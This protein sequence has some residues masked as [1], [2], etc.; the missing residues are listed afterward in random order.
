M[1]EDTRAIAC[2]EGQ[3]TAYK[4][5]FSSVMYA[6]G[7]QLRQQCIHPLSHLSGPLH[8]SFLMQGVSLNPKLTNF[9]ILAGPRVPGICPSPPLQ[10]RDT[11]PLSCAHLFIGLAGSNWGLYTLQGVRTHVCTGAQ[12]HKH[13]DTCSSHTTGE[14]S[15]GGRRFCYDTGSLTEPEAVLD[16]LT[17]GLLRSCL[18]PPML[19]LQVWVVFFF[20]YGW[21]GFEL[22]TSW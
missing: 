2:C 16:W 14:T 4:S 6:P 21:W 17:N 8:L 18:Q 12:T 13:A 7:I 10:H 22:R 1:C 20:L 15:G 11:G 19:E 5:W 3:M 9:A